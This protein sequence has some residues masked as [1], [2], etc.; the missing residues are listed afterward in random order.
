VTEPKEETYTIRGNDKN[1]LLTIL[2][3]LGSSVPKIKLVR[4]VGTL[5]NTILTFCP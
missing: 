5:A 2:P 3:L 4:V 1:E